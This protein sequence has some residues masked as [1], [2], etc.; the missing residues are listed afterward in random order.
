MY[1]EIR[2]LHRMLAKILKGTQHLGENHRSKDNVKVDFNMWNE[3][4]C[5]IIPFIVGLC[6]YS[7]KISVFVK[8]GKFVIN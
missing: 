1:E 3:L 6:Q 5:L 4:T 7:N 8:T 2:K